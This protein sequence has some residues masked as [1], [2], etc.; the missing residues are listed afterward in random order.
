MIHSVFC[1]EQDGW[2]GHLLGGSLIFGLGCGRDAGVK[3]EGVVKQ[4]F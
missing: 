1:Y 3:Y 2:D 4:R